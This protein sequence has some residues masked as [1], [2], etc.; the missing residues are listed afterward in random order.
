MAGTTRMVGS[1][2]KRIRYEY[3]KLILDLICLLVIPRSPRVFVYF[4]RVAFPSLLRRV[5]LLMSRLC[6]PAFVPSPACRSP[7]CNGVNYAASWSLS[8]MYMS[9]VTCLLS[10][11][12]NQNLDFVYQSI[13]LNLSYAYCSSLLVIARSHERNISLGRNACL[14]RSTCNA[15]RLIIVGLVLIISMV[16]LRHEDDV[17]WFFQRSCCCGG[18]W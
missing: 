13:L 4:W 16:H 2:L 1:R 12:I 9:E 10:V 3:N 6:Q 8:I 14:Y 18:R 15:G 7:E 5:S 17:I 11:S